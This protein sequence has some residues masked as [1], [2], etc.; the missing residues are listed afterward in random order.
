MNTRKSGVVNGHLT[1]SR[2]LRDGVEIHKAALRSGLNTRLYPRQVLQVFSQDGEYSTAFTHGLPLASTLSGVTF[3]QDLRMARGQLK[4]AG[5]ARPRGATFSVGRSRGA[6]RRYAEKLGYPVVVKPALGDSTIDVFRGIKGRR[7]FSRA[8]DAL[9]IPNDERPNSTQASYGLTELRK[10]GFKNGKVTV[11]PGYR[12]LVEEQIPG[13]YYRLLVLDAEIIDVVRC[14]GG[15]WGDRA[16]RLKS[17]SYW[18]AGITEVVQKVR[19][20][21]PGLSVMSI[22]VVLPD[23]THT[24]GGDARTPVVVEVSERPWLEVQH[25]VDPKGASDLASKILR[26]GLGMENLQELHRPVIEADAMFQGVVDPEAFAAALVK[27]AA[28]FNVSVQLQAIDKT[29]GR[30]SAAFQGTPNLVGWLVETALDRGV[31]GH[32]AMRADVS[33]VP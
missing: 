20:G 13:D 4:K 25:R 27:F 7:D 33:Q 3:T 14:H 26:F 21:L 8:V 22:D 28:V 6:A 9:L 16:D 5:V 24:R 15:P 19:R 23:R 10:P 18:P 12:F 32:V 30:V 2:G 1:V 31:D 11:P 17:P 29:L